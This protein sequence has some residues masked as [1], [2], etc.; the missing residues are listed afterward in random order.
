MIVLDLCPHEELNLDLSLRRATLYP[1]SY[2][3]GLLWS[4]LSSEKNK[5]QNPINSSIESM[6]DGS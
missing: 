6:S 4:L 3:D 2:E 5:S 1:L